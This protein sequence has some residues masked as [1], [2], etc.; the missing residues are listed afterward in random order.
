LTTSFLCKRSDLPALQSARELTAATWG[1]ELAAALKQVNILIEDPEEEELGSKTH[2][3][4]VI[5]FGVKIKNALRDNWTDHATDVFDIGFA[6]RFIF[7][8]ESS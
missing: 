8:S 4:N 3:Q 2:R 7:I 5:S 1:Q 6:Y